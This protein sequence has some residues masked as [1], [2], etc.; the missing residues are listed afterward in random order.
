MEIR[1]KLQLA[2]IQAR[3]GQLRALS[4]TMA[5]VESALARAEDEVAAGAVPSAT[6]PKPVPEWAGILQKHERNSARILQKRS[7]CRSSCELEPSPS[8]RSCLLAY[9]I[10]SLAMAPP[11]TLSCAL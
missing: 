5:D 1:G 6:T 10:F 9:Q 11:P 2:D 4:S 7:T 8:R 3:V